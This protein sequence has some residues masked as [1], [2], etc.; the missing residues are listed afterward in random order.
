[1]R[2][3]CWVLGLQAGY[4]ALTGI[5]PFVSI[6]TFQMVTGPKAE[7][8]L[9]RMV[10]LLALVIGVTLLTAALSARVTPEIIL[11]AIASAA[12]FAAIDVGYAMIGRIARIYLADAAV[13]ASF[14]AALSLSAARVRRRGV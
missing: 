4:F 9:V 8:W 6:S 14:I 13:E 10:G 11:L 7:L 3:V 1:M 5:W 2:A 12:A